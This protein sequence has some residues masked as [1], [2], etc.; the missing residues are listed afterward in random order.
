MSI[1]MH[2]DIFLDVAFNFLLW[3]LYNYIW[4]GTLMGHFMDIMDFVYIF[5]DV[6]YDDTISST[7]F[8]CWCMDVPMCICCY[9]VYVNGT[10]F[11][12]VGYVL[13]DAY[14]MK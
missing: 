11:C 12:D 5:F 10:Y 13:C 7:W 9:D 4:F 2:F 14:D 1:L 3:Y 8:L 6:L